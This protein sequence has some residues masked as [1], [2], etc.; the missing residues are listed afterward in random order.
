M[1]KN[2]KWGADIAQKK[3][4]TSLVKQSIAEQPQDI[5]FAIEELI[6]F[7][8]ECSLSGLQTAMNTVNVAIASI[9]LKVIEDIAEYG[10]EDS[11]R[12]FLPVDAKE[13]QSAVFYLTK[14]VRLLGPLSALCSNHKIPAIDMTDKAFSELLHA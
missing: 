3:P 4:A 7:F 8:S 5:M 10:E 12:T 6:P 9:S 13:M 14:F 2:E 11:N 1:S